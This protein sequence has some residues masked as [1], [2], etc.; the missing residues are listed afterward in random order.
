MKQTKKMTTK[1]FFEAYEILTNEW[2]KK[3][4]IIDFYTQ[5]V[6]EG[7]QMVAKTLEVEL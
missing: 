1:E 7:I 5:G 4:L 3:D 2:E 6:K